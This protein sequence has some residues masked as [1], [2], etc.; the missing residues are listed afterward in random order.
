MVKEQTP[1][2]LVGALLQQILRMSEDN[3]LPSEVSSLYQLHHKHNTRPTSSQLRE[4][5][6]K[7]VLKYGVVHVVVDALDEY[8]EFDEGAVQF[9]SMIRSLGP[10]VKVLCTSRH[11]AVFENYFSEEKSLQVA[12]Q[13]ED[14]RKFLDSEMHRQ[15]RLSRHIKADPGLK[16]DIMNTIT[17]ES[18]G[19]LVYSL[20]DCILLL[21]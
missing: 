12:A 18:Q 20:G 6:E 14:I 8:A 7:I 15:H 16:E 10:N 2:A 17:E 4:I 19:M 11:S 9:I 5:L 13:T 1:A 3:A 21:T